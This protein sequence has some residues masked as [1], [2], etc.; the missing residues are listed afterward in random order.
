M[1][2]RLLCI[3]FEACTT[4]RTLDLQTTEDSS[5]A[6]GSTMLFVQSVSATDEIVASNVGQY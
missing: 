1:L 4:I 6:A 5:H 2:A 3:F